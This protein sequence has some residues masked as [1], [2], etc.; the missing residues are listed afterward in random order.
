[1][2]HQ[3]EQ[4]LRIFLCDDDFNWL[5]D[6]TRMLFLDVA[7]KVVGTAN[8]GRTCIE[9]VKELQPNFV[10]LDMSLP[11]MDGLQ[12]A[13]T[14][15]KEQPNTFIILMVDYQNPELIRK[16]MAAGVREILQKPFTSGEVTRAV[17][18]ILAQERQRLEQEQRMAPG[19][20]DNELIHRLGMEQDKTSLGNQGLGVLKQ[21]VVTVY[22]PKGG[23][24]KTTLA[25][26][27][28]LAIQTNEMVKL[29]VVLL[30]FDINFGNIGA[31]LRF[32]PT[33][34]IM[35]WIPVLDSLDYET[36]DNLLVTHPTGLKVLLA[37]V[38]PTDERFVTAEVAEKVIQAL[39]KFYDIIIIDTGQVLRD[40]TIVALDEATR[41]LMVSTLD[42]P[43]LRDIYNIANTFRDLGIDSSK[44]RFVINR[45]GRNSD[46]RIDEVSE[47][48][49]FPLLGKVPDDPQVQLAINQVEPLVVF[50]K[51][52]PF[53][54]AIRQ[55]A[56][57]FCPVFGVSDN[58]KKKRRLF[59]GSGAPK[60]SLFPF[61]F[62]GRKRA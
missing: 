49:P 43:A 53:S 45:F 33:R 50:K 3:V 24:G 51:N 17:Q 29:K 59:G 35:D 62:F 8:E 18:Q 38:Q 28:A 60:K 55:I 42:V 4:K 22:S 56:H 1:M 44:A 9:R 57:S 37:P 41:I 10:L 58:R 39:K 54:E 47:L 26:N 32:N 30:D 27:L 15:T 48:I 7:F 31:M 19:L 6:L 46:L 36:V 23:V 14:L 12:V 61:G 52:S 13:Q 2:A 16:A 21:Q 20:R 40:S 5:D 25:T 11:D 34:T